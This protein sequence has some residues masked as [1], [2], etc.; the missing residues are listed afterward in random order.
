MRRTLLSLAFLVALSSVARADP[1]VIT[2]GTANILGPAAGP[3][4]GSF[5]LLAEG[6]SAAGHGDRNSGG[7]TSIQGGSDF[8][9]TFTGNAGPVMFLGTNLNFTLAPFI[10][11]DP[12]SGPN[13]VLAS[14]AFTM[15]GVLDIRQLS[16]GLPVLFNSPVTGSGFAL[17]EYSLNGPRYVPTN[18]TYYFGATE[19]IPEPATMLLLGTGRAGVVGSAR[20]RRKAGS[21]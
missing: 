16:P 19:P 5:T 8:R 11:P 13:T 1:L 7:F 3:N 15:T 21:S 12:I 18:V 20:R 4:V 2:G 10:L 9:G 14:T 6:F 17:I